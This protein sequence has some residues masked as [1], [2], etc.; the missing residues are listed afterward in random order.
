MT[1]S[2]TPDKFYAGPVGVVLTSDDLGMSPAIDR[3]ILAALAAGRIS[4]TNLM[5]PC[6]HAAAAAQQVVAQKLPCGIHLTLTS[7]WSRVRWASLTGAPGLAAPDGNLWPTHAEMA[8]HA[9]DSEILEEFRAQLMQCLQWG[10]LPT[11]VDVH[12]LPAGSPIEPVERRVLALAELTASELGLCCTYSG[13]GSPDDG[14]RSAHFS[15]ARTLAGQTPEQVAAWIRSLEPGLH[16]LVLHLGEDT[17]ELD[18]L[19]GPEAL[20]ARTYRAAD[21]ALLQGP[22]LPLLAECGLPVLKTRDLPQIYLHPSTQG[23]R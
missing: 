13:A 18:E 5:V 9:S 1:A 6:P 19:S 23:S 3:P 8:A 17:P 11:H 22:L 2:R 15:S 21:L 12:M 7:E 16:H 4:S 14:R 10:L 20:W